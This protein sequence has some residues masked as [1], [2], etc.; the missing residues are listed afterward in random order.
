MSTT[1]HQVALRSFTP[2]ALNLLLETKG[3]RLAQAD[4]PSLWSAEKK[5]EHL[6]YMRDT[7]KSSWEF[8]DYVFKIT[9]VSR[10]FTQQLERTRTG[11]YA[12][13]SLR[14]SDVREHEVLCP[15][16]I[17]EQPEWLHEWQRIEQLMMN[18]Y[19]K[20]IDDGAA[21]QD[22]RGLLPTNITTSIF[23]KFNLRSLHEMAKLRL[24]VRTQGEY[25]NVF[26]DMRSLVISVH[27]WAAEFLEVHCVATG[28]CAFPRYGKAECP[29][30]LP[31]MDRS[32]TIIHARELF[33][34]VRHE[35]SPKARD[36]KAM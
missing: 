27:P 33:W 35:A 11:S 2:D 16:S 26:R 30:Y 9:H 29:V 15:P 19:A 21:V 4:P 25:Q 24:C 10:N 20:L 6:D 1:I 8:V 32:A 28:I 18:G 13:L 34:S 31:D 3:T 5:Q 22:A 14:A 36:G 7:I 23:A 17:Q 12:E